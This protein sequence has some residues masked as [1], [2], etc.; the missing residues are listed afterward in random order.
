MNAHDFTTAHIIIPVNLLS[1]RRVVVGNPFHPEVEIP[2]VSVRWV[3]EA[4]RCPP[5]FVFLRFQP[6]QS[7]E[8]R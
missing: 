6:G 8:R 4:K 3:S 5:Y 7:I 1:E 2:K